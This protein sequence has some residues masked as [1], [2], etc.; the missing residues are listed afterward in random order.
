ADGGPNASGPK[1]VQIRL[2]YLSGGASYYWTGS[3]FSSSTVNASTA[4]QSI[5]TG[6]PGWSYPIPITWPSDVS[7]AMTLESRAEDNAVLADGTGGGNIGVAAT[8][9]VDVVS[10]NVDFVAPAGAITLPAANAFVNSL[11]LITGTASDDLAGV[12]NVNVEISSGAGTRSYWTGSGWSG[13][14]GWN[15]ATLY[16]SSWTYA[17]PTWTTGIQFYLR[18]QVIDAAGNSF[19]TQASTFTYETQSPTI[20][21]S[22]PTA[23]AF[24]SG[25]LLSTPFAGTASDPVSAVSSVTVAITDIDGGPNYF[26]GTSFAAGGPFNLAAQGTTANWTY[27]NAALSLQNDH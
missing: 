20:T 19:V 27:N 8:P 1:D 7:H 23:G 9:G 16:T 2:S 21:M 14:Q 4:W 13:S 17:T 22:Q 24:Y 18:L 6:G 3:Q 11:P 5:T 26:N 25:V 10:F 15:A 12:S